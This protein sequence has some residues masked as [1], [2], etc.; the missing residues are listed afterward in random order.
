MTE[1]VIMNN[2]LLGT[3]L[4]AAFSFTILAAP[5]YAT[6]QS[7]KAITG[8]H[9]Q[10]KCASCGGDGG[11]G[12]GTPPPPP[13][14]TVKITFFSVS[15]QNKTVEIHDSTGLV[16]ILSPQA[17]TVSMSR[18]GHTSQV[19]FSAALLQWSGGDS[20]KAAAMNARFQTLLANPKNTS[21]LVP[22]MAS[23]N[24]LKIKSV[25]KA[26]NGLNA[27]VMMGP[28]GGNFP[29]DMSFD[30]NIASDGDFGGWGPLTLVIGLMRAAAA[31]APQT[32]TTG[33]IGSKITAV[34]RRTKLGR[35]PL[36]I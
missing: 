7:V 15:P 12:G 28:W 11:G 16:A 31:L 21:M 20:A 30:C 10:L 23:Q 24:S 36:L 26:N 13:Q 4:L 33:I 27:N 25:F 19:S 34:P 1:D 8:L 17:N 6:T 18:S 9:P 14:Q 5:S 22:S 2:R 3:M 29:C 35:P 32:T